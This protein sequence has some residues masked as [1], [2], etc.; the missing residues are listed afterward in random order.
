MQVTVSLPLSGPVLAAY[1]DQARLIAADVMVTVRAARRVLHHLAD[2]LDAGLLDEVTG[3]V[4]AM[5]TVV[6]LMAT[7]TLQLEQ[8]LPVLDATA[9][10]LSM[11]NTT[12]A[13]VNGTLAQIDAIPGVRQARR[14]VSRT[15]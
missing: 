9:P 13:Q 10:T 1:A 12:L 3:A 11:V 6:G 7:V 4:R 14:L 15:S 5:E 8:A 2:A